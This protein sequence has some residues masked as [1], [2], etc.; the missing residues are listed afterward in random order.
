[1]IGCGQEV[2]ETPNID[3]ELIRL[4]P[5]DVTVS[6]SGEDDSH[7][8]VDNLRRQIRDELGM[9]DETTHDPD[10]A[11]S[12]PQNPTNARRSEARWA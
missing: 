12:I 5:I 11:L 7:L 1:M 3:I 9:R 6:S 8:V 10:S 2:I 4:N